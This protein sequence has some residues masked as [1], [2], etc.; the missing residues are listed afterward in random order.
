MK[1]P[2]LLLAAASAFVPLARADSLHIARVDRPEPRDLPVAASQVETPTVKAI[3]DRAI[4]AAP[5]GYVPSPS[6]CP[7]PAPKIRSGSTMG[8]DEKAWLP[9]RRKETIVHIRRLL[10]R[11]AITGFDSEQYFGNAT[12]NSTKLPN[13]GIAISGGGYRAMVGGAGAIAAWDARSA[14]S[15]EKGNLGGLLQS[16]T[17]ISGLSGGDWLVGSLYVN[18]FTSV[19]SAVDAPLIW[20]L[21][22]SIFKGPDQYSVRGYYTD[23]FNEVESKSKANFN[24]SASDYWG[25]MLAYQMVNASNG[26]P[27]YTWSSIANDSD[28]SSG[29][30]PMPFLLANGRN[31]EKKVIT[32]GNSTVYEFTPWEL[33]SSDPNLAGWVPL[34]Y[35]GTAFKD[36]DVVD[37]GS[38]VT[39]FDNAGFVMGTTSSIYTQSISY[40]KD[41]NKKYIPSDVPDFAIKTATKLIAALSDSTA[42]DIAEWSPN[43]F[44]GFNPATNRNANSSR[45]NLVDGSEDAQNVPFHPHLLPDRAVDVVFAYDASSDT[46]YGWP[47]GSALAATYERSQQLAF[48]DVPFAAVPDKNTVRNL[49]LNTRPAFFG[50]NATNFTAHGSAVAPLV[51]WL[52]NHPYVYNG[53]LTTFTWTV[54]DPERAAL[55]DNGWAVATQLNA[56]RDTEWPACVACAI[57]AR[58]FYRANATVPAQCA[59]CFDRYC[60]KGNTNTTTPAGPYDPTYYGKPIIVND[61]AA[62]LARAPAPLLASAVLLVAAM[63]AL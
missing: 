41:N 26:G 30:A 44:R 39:G 14:G 58:S 56:T 3:V 10:K 22:N 43:P 19:Q 42:Y 60:W 52:P 4:N 35:V 5:S 45:L 18:N 7:D 33:G 38:C 36:G 40:L 32:S 29:K 11:L 13:I 46:E 57:L 37:Q 24:V 48:R 8:P 16:A 61:N 34:R 54:R 25:R 23:V 53:N 63:L 62:A 17:Y 1:H 6:A 50:C 47:D 28:F 20:Q 15:E 27:G 9:G 59:K 2:A 31:S 21:E 12:Y 49:G 51:V 55:I